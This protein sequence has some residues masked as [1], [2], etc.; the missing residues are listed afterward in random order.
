MVNEKIA[1]D[2]FSKYAFLSS[3]LVESGFSHVSNFISK[4]GVSVV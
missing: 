1:L 2:V 3:Y 4:S